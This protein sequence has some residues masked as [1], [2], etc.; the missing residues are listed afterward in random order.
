MLDAI[1][2]QGMSVLQYIEKKPGFIVGPITQVLG[3]IIDLVFRV[4]ST[5]GQPN[6]LGWS[7]IILTIIA[8]TMMLPLG[9]KSQKSMLRMQR[10]TPEVNKIKAKYGGSKDPELQRK[11][12]AEIQALY[13]TN[14]VNPLSG[15]LPLLL[16]MPIF[17]ALSYLLRQSYLFIPSIH[18]IYAEIGRNIEQMDNFQ[19]IIGVIGRPKIPKDLWLTM[20]DGTK[21]FFVGEVPGMTI[22]VSEAF[23]NLLKLVN[24]FNAEDWKM[25]WEGMAGNAELLGETTKWVAQ[26]DAIETFY[27]IGLLGNAGMVGIGVLIPIFT[28]VTTFLSSF[29][30]NKT[31]PSGDAAAKTQQKVMMVVM[32]VMMFFMTASMSAGVGLYWIV[33]SV[34][35]TVQQYFLYKYFSKKDGIKEAAK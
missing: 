23:D 3:F 22:T 1:V 29:V 32:P 16:Q 15:C 28:A 14:K 9:V 4:I 27:G 6:S 12:N 18:D 30:M 10:L 19:Q 2:M 34:Y 17:F 11:M 26:K 13:A 5:L 7:I 35:Q 24:R 20:A 25:I 8:R 21:A 33:S 31:N